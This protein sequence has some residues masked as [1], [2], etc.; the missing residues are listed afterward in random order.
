MVPYADE[1]YRSGRM[2]SRRTVA[3]SLEGQ[4]KGASAVLMRNHSVLRDEGG[5]SRQR[6]PRVRDCV[7]LTSSL[8][9]AESVVKAL[10]RAGIQVQ[11]VA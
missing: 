1:E 6:D 9:A 8:Q 10:G 5:E 7:F 4:R 2:E 3:Y 11:P